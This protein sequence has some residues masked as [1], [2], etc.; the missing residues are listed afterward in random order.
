MSGFV[1]KGALPVSYFLP[2]RA[3]YA[4]GAAKGSLFGTISWDAEGLMI[5]MDT[6]I[7]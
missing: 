2:V 3:T 1:E 4:L 7:F 5:K 6:L